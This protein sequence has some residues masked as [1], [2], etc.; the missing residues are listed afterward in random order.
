[1]SW[2]RNPARTLTKRQRQRI[3]ERDG[4]EC[5]ACHGTRCANHN[6]EVAHITAHADGGTDH[7]DNL[8]TLGARPCHL[9]ET[10]A[11]AARGRARKQRRRTPD[12]HPG[13]VTPTA[14][15]EPP[16]PNHRN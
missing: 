16:P 10:K 3:I 9:E 2:Q 13:L 15:H 1:M 7:P 11:D 8:R 4:H 5:Q 12:P 14:P 6:L